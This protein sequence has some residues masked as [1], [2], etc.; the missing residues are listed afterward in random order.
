M[1]TRKLYWKFC[2]RDWFAVAN[3]FDFVRH[4]AVTK[5]CRGDKILINLPP[6][7][8]AFTPGDLSLQPI[9]AESAYDLPLDCTH[10]AIC[11]SNV[12]LRFVSLC[13]SA[14]TFFSWN[15][16]A[17]GGRNLFV[18]DT[19]GSVKDW[20]QAIA[21]LFDTFILD[22]RK[23]VYMICYTKTGDVSPG[24]AKGKQKKSLRQGVLFE[25]KR[26]A[27]DVVWSQENHK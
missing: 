9:A 21:V 13:V 10:K 20:C 19:L 4:V 18:N 5:F 15:K 7:V 26:V 24:E 14:F 2:H 1:W 23:T 11:C 27:P 12:L 8:K 6:N 16:S 22:Q 3:W 17:I 25:M